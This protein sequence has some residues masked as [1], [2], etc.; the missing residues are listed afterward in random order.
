MAAFN[1]GRVFANK[2]P[3]VETVPELGFYSCYLSPV[4]TVIPM[5]RYHNSSDQ[6]CRS[7][8]DPGHIREH[9]IVHFILMRQK[10]FKYS[11]KSGF[12]NVVLI[13]GY[14]G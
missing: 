5:G 10:K 3:F 14:I 12:I 2:L 4:K 11:F 9:D 6:V 13:S 7:C 8:S 1:T